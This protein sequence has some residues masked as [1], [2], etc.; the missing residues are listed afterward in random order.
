M[1]AINCTA[2]KKLT[3]LPPVHPT[4]CVKAIAVTS[5]LPASCD[6]TCMFEQRKLKQDINN[7]YKQGAANERSRQIAQ[8]LFYFAGYISCRI[9]AGVGKTY[10]HHRHGKSRLKNI[11]SPAIAKFNRICLAGQAAKKQ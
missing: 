8:R 6:H 2:I 7:R 4:G 11:F 9:P 5:S 3:H 10:I 1:V